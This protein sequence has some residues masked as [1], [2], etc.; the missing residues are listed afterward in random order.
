MSFA[1]VV[2]SLRGPEE[3]QLCMPVVLIKY[4]N[5]HVDGMADLE[6]SP[7]VWEIRQ[8]QTGSKGGRL[9]K[10]ERHLRKALRKVSKG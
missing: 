1:N 5:S 4:K 2:F 9:T 7:T 10:N 3:S 8:E 6:K